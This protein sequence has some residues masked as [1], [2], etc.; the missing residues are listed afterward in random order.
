YQLVGFV[1]S[2]MDP[3]ML[4]VTFGDLVASV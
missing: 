1:P 3:M 2:P 4:M